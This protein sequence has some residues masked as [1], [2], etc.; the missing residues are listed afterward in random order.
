MAAT[1][2]KAY[3][4]PAPTGGWNAADPLDDMAENEA[5]ELVNWFPE[6]ES[7][8][9][10]RGSRVHSTDLGTG[11]V[12]TLAVYAPESGSDKLV[13]F[14]GGKI[15]NATTYDDP[16]TELATGFTSNFWQTVNFKQRL[17][18]VNGAD[19]PQ[20]YDGSTVS[21]AN[22]TGI[23]D[24]ANLIHVTAY[25]TRLYFIEKNSTS[26]WYGGIGAITGAL[27]EYDL[28]DLL[29]LGGSLHFVGTWSADT[30]TGLQNLLVVISTKGEVLTFTGSYPGDATSWSIAG[31]Y[32]LPPLLG[33]KAAINS[34]ADLLMVMRD[35][36]YPLSAVLS[37]Q[38]QLAEHARL[39]YKIQ[40]AFKLA[41]QQYGANTNWTALMHPDAHML[42]VNIPLSASTAEQYIMNTLTGAWCRFTGMNACSWILFNNKPYF[43]GADGKIYE[44]DTLESD[45]GAAISTS[46][47]LAYNY[48]K[49]RANNKAFL[50][51]QPLM[52]ATQSA[53]FLLNVDTDFAQ[54]SITGSVQT[55]GT[56]GLYFDFDYDSSYGS[57]TIAFSEW[58]AVEGF[59]CAG[60]LQ[61]KGSFKDIELSLNAFKLTY[62]TAGVL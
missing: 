53:E 55:V 34:A 30:G 56:G 36:V 47:K 21:A 11:A 39:T 32:L 3:T 9:L 28:G 62:Q 14:A 5:I 38:G 40:P 19:Q 27:T 54:T 31:R 33:R 6:A 16:A 12:S 26:L 50:M 10:R 15:W 61:I 13:G 49:D 18:C 20:Q 44:A 25:K 8:N 24:D 4:L 52:R 22:Y 45:S 43:G 46:A 29:T 35:G 57:D 58:Q 60:S 23:G 42:Y 2:T 51:A 59:G 41:A 7:V 1:R 48:F 17:V 37:A